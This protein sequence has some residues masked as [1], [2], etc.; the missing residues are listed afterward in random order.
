MSFIT[1]RT[2]GT[3]P[4]VFHA[5]GPEV[6]HPLWPE[7]CDRFF[8]L[9][10]RRIG[11]IPDLTI[12]TWNNGHPGMGI[13]ERSLDH[14]G[15]PYVVTGRGVEE[16]V[17]ARDKPRLTRDALRTIETPYVL[18]IDSGDAIL[19]DDPAHLV[20]W[21][22]TRFRCDLVFGA[23]R[24]NFPNLKSYKEF[25]D[26]L[27]GA[28]ASEFRYLNGGVWIGRTEFCREFF[29]EA[30]ETPPDEVRPAAE[31][32]ILKKLF[33]R[34][35][36]RVQLDYTCAMFQNLGFVFLSIFDFDA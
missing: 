26:K 36:P 14:L 9:P 11:P 18:G 20:G 8:A 32:G 13:L 22:E 7:V 35:V 28:A 19:V 34:H 24:I 17:N 4:V 21:L 3:R 27:P 31:Q 12:L 6:L 5:Q 25:E 15:I 10:P 29:A 16:W 30:C 1:N 23:D 2:F 33:Q